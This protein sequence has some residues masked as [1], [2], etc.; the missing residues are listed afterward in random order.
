VKVVPILAL[1]AIAALPAGRAEPNQVWTGWLVDL[2]CYLTDNTETGNDHM[3]MKRCGTTCLRMGRPAGIVTPD[4][5]F[6]VLL[7][8]SPDIAEF[9]GQTIRVTGNSGTVRSWWISSR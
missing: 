5:R 3:D 7:L 6:F 8:A 4:K 2:S 9:V 1:C